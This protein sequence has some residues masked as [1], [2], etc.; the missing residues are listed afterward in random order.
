MNTIAEIVHSQVHAWGGQCNKNLGQAFVIVWRIGDEETLI[1]ANSVSILSRAQQ[2]GRGSIL[3]ASGGSGGDGSV[4]GKAAANSPAKPDAGGGV[5]SEW[6]D[7][8]T[9]SQISDSYAFMGRD[10]RDSRPSIYGHTTRGSINTA[11]VSALPRILNID[12][13]RVPGVDEIADKALIGYLKV[14]AE[15]NRSPPVLNFRRDERL[16]TNAT[17]PDILAGV[18]SI[19]PRSNASAAMAASGFPSAVPSPAPTP[20]A[21]QASVDG[22]AGDSLPATRARRGSFLYH[23]ERRTYFQNLVHK[24][25]A[26]SDD[27]TVRMGFGLHAGWAIEGAVGSVYK[28]SRSAHITIATVLVL[29]MLSVCVAAMGFRWMPR[30]SLR[31]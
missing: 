12:L 25:A 27:F 8:D 22:A 20:R 7:D 13:K 2:Q 19:S 31:T 5:A 17:A 24:Q 26:A 21:R 18:P 1:A 6:E 28:V 29:T 16:R 30:I 10:A 15:I 23:Q 9:K 4:R 11:S 14:I 3:M